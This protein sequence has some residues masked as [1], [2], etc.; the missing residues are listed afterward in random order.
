MSKSC[1]QLV[2]K[3]GHMWVVVHPVCNNKEQYLYS[4]FWVHD[5]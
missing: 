2:K 5:Y 1:G 3:N 4:L